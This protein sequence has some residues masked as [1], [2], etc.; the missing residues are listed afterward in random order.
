MNRIMAYGV[1]YTYNM[2]HNNSCEFTTHPNSNLC[3]IS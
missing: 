3:L 2:D 1:V